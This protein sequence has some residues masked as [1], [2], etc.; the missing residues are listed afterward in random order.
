M[1]DVAKKT[2]LTK[3]KQDCSHLKSCVAVFKL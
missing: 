2:E 3:I 1:A